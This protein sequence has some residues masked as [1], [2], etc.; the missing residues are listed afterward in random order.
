M[1]A[2]EDL[3]D[4]GESLRGAGFKVSTQQLMAAQQLLLRLAAEG[5][6]PPRRAGL[7]SWLAPV[8]CTSAGEQGLFKGLYRAWLRARFVEER[9]DD[10]PPAPAPPETVARRWSSVVAALL[11]LVVA[12]GISWLVWQSIREPLQVPAAPSSAPQAPA[13]A[14]IGALGNGSEL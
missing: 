11:V 2:L 5:A 10:S 7:A 4:L 14:P 3:V 12:A 1:L 13:S 8:L 9:D 6:F